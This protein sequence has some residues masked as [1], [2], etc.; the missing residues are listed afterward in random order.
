M[1]WNELAVDEEDAGEAQ[2]TVQVPSMLVVDP[3]ASADPA[4]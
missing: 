1:G 3:A 2:G 4:G